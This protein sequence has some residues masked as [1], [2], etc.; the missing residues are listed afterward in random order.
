MLNL[1][2][3]ALRADIIGTVR[4]VRELVDSGVEPLSLMSRLAT[5]ITGSFGFTE[6]QRKGFFKKESRKQKSSMY[7]N[8]CICILSFLYICF[9][10]CQIHHHHLFCFS[11]SDKKL[12]WLRQAMKT[13]SEAEKQVR[14]SNDKT[15]WLT[16]AL[17]QLGPDPRSCTTNFPASCTGTS[18]TQSPVAL[19]DNEVADF[20]YVSSGR[21]TWEDNIKNGPNTATEPPC[22]LTNG[23]KEAPLYQST[24]EIHSQSKIQDEKRQCHQHH[25]D[26][27]LHPSHILSS[28]KLDDIWYQVLQRCWPLTL[29]QLLNTHG[30]LISISMTDGISTFRI[31]L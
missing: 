15:T 11:V 5:L 9:L 16:A 1:L 10:K 3:C 22:A 8:L 25:S 6:K 26:D 19:D 29:R 13:L 2:D 20:E 30:K 7:S 24:L 18:V 28:A 17:L 12:E 4:K 21:R 27:F 31:W 14:V 23:Q